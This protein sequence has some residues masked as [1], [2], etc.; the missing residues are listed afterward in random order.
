MTF[1]DS[2]RYRRYDVEGTVPVQ[3]LGMYLNDRLQDQQTAGHLRPTEEP[4]V[5]R[6]KGWYLPTCI[7]L[8][9]Y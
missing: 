3:W 8:P 2:V 9:T 4:Q 6:P 7:H 1:I 5:A